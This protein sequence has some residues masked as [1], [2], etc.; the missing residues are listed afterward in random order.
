M[1][2]QQAREKYIESTNDAV[3]CIR[4]WFLQRREKKK[5]GKSP[6]SSMEGGNP[7][8][9]P[10]ETRTC[11]AFVPAFTFSYAAMTAFSSRILT[12]SINAGGKNTPASKP[13]LSAASSEI[14]LFK[15]TPSVLRPRRVLLWR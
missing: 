8:C 14:A 5:K 7:Y 3:V 1:R 2:A 13:S 15:E 11:F 4:P 9:L 6:L 12:S 10:G